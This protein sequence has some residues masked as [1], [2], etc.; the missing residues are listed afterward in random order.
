M[1]LYRQLTF[2]P[3]PATLLKP[4]TVDLP[5]SDATHPQDVRFGLWDEDAQFFVPLESTRDEV[6]KRVRVVLPAGDYPSTTAT[7]QTTINATP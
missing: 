2:S 1:T 3:E 4:I 5:Y 7:V 6:K